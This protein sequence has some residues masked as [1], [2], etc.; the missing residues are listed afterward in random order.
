MA[1]LRE[2]PNEPVDRIIHAFD[3]KGR[4]LAEID[5]DHDFGWMAISPDHRHMWTN[6][7]DPLPRV[8]EWPL[9]PILD[10][11]ERLDAGEPASN[12]ELCPNGRF[13]G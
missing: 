5:T 9:P 1:H 12:L 10:L 4:Y 3:W 6:H 8:A 11:I 13:G 7:Q 2:R